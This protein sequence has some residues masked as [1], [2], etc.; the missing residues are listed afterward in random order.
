MFLHQQFDST[1][2]TCESKSSLNY[3]NKGCGQYQWTTQRSNKVPTTFLDFDNSWKNGW[4]NKISRKLP[5]HLCVCWAGKRVFEAGHEQMTCCRSLGAHSAM[6]PSPSSCFPCPSP[7]KLSLLV[8]SYLLSIVYFLFYE[9]R[10]EKKKAC[11][12]SLHLMTI[13]NTAKIW[14]KSHLQQ[15]TKKGKSLR[16]QYTKQ[17]EKKK[18][19]KT[20]LVLIT[21][22]FA[23][24][25]YRGQGKTVQNS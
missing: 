13:R 12:F 19:N 20:R 9:K 1:S 8:L 2:T 25:G 11:S 5:L 21:T 22:R 23:N 7:V 6:L 18:S 3:L 4:K 10:K 14:G 16:I 24:T 17:I 15:K